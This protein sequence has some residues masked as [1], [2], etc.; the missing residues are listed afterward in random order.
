[1]AA[2]DKRFT[3]VPVYDQLPMLYRPMDGTASNRNFTTPVAV[4]G[5]PQEWSVAFDCSYLFWRRVQ[6]DTGISEPF[7]LVCTENLAAVER[8]KMAPRLL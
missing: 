3:L 8:L 4:S 7:R 6:A 5:A 2:G 1:M